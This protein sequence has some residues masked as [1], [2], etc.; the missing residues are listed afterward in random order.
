MRKLFACLAVVLAMSF[1]TNA[2]ECNCGDKCECR[3]KCEC[4]DKC[5][6]GST[7]YVGMGLS[8]PTMFKDIGDHIDKELTAS[9]TQAEAM[10][11]FKIQDNKV[12][13][14]GYAGYC[15]NK[16]FAM[17]LGYH[18]YGHIKMNHEHVAT[19]TTTS[20]LRAKNQLVYL[21][22]VAKKELLDRFDVFGKLGTGW[23]KSHLT[24]T[25]GT[26]PLGSGNGIATDG[27]ALVYGI[28]AEYTFDID[29]GIRIDY[30]A[31]KA[32]GKCDNRSHTP[33][34]LTLSLFYILPY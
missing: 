4:R 11:I 2:V 12:G 14:F 34:L 1:A 20:T 10:D 32:H 19:T 8:H 3:P 18:K 30:T 9:T 13:Y 7:W 6:C 27:F 25:G 22:G 17:E 16:N 29:V 31:L 24:Q 26:Y 5:D 15:I 28:G 23:F 33:D 21:C